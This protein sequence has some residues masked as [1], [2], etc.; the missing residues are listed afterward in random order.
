[1]RLKGKV[2]FVTGAGGGIGS[3]VCRKFLAE[4]A[5][6]AATDINTDAAS[7]ALGDSIAQG[8][9]IVIKCDVGDPEEVRS[10]IARSVE[11][12]GGLNVLVNTAGGSTPNDGPVTEAPDEEFWRVMRLDLFGTF[13]VCKQGIPEVIKSGGG[14]VINLSSVTALHAIEGRDCYTAAKGGITS[15]TRSMA[16]GYAKDGV[17]VNA[18]SPGLTLT[19][20]VQAMYETTPSMQTFAER[21]LMGPCTPEDMA[22]MAV[23]LASDESMRVTGQI[24]QVD[25]G[26]TIH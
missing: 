10:A 23:F 1:M 5:R 4:G 25:S 12:L 13:Q 26:V 21:H 16:G 8:E 6:V 15:M 24:L 17:R 14:S 9:A 11:A 20:R 19:P 22:N 3:A 7:A 2:A 18:I